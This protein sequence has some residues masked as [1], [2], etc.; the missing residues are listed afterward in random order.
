LDFFFPRKL[1]WK[2]VFSRSFKKLS[3]LDEHKNGSALRGGRAERPL[4]ISM[5]K[6][7]AALRAGRSSQ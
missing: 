7:I 1:F 2:K 5:L 6:G 3:A 4:P